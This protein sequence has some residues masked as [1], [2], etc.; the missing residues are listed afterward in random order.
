MLDR[1]GQRAANLPSNLINSIPSAA[2][3]VINSVLPKEYSEAQDSLPGV[4]EVYDIPEPPGLASRQFAVD[5]PFHLAGSLPAY[6]LPYGPMANISKAGTI[7]RIATEAVSGFVGGAQ[8]GTKSAELQAILGGTFGATAKLPLKAKMLLAPFI[9]FG[10]KEIAEWQGMDEKSATLTG[11]LQGALPI[12]SHA[13]HSALQGRTPAEVA[14]P[15]VL[16][17]EDLTRIGPS[18]S[19]E[20]FAPPQTFP[21]PTPPARTPIPLPPRGSPFVERQAEPTHIGPPFKDITPPSPTNFPV[22]AVEIPLPAGTESLASDVLGT[23]RPVVISPAPK[24]KGVTIP[25]YRS[26]E[27]PAYEAPVV[28][29]RGGMG[30]TPPAPTPESEIATLQSHE[31]VDK[32]PEIFDSETQ[33]TVLGELGQHPI[34]IKGVDG[35]VYPAVMN[36]W[37]S[38]GIPS[39][40]R[41]IPNGDWSHGILAKGEK[42][43]T[44]VPQYGSYVEYQPPV[45]PQ[46]VPESVEE[47]AQVQPEP[48][49]Q[50]PKVSR[51]K[52]IS[53]EDYDTL[54]KFTTAN[55]LRVVPGEA[56]AGS[57]MFESMSDTVVGKPSKVRFAVPEGTSYAQANKLFKSARRDRIATLQSQKPTKIIDPSLPFQN[58][59]SAKLTPAEVEKMGVKTSDI[60]PVNAPETP[61]GKG[62][63]R[64]TGGQAGASN[65]DTLVKM[66]A[67]G[68]GGAIGY[69][70][71]DEYRARGLVLGLMA[72][73]FAGHFGPKIFAAVAGMNPRSAL[74]KSFSEVAQ[75]ASRGGGDGIAKFARFF[76]KNFG[77]N[78]VIQ[79]GLSKA[80]GEAHLA[81][82]LWDRS[83]KELSARLP[84]L[85]ATER[86][87]IQQFGLSNDPAAHTAM[88]HGVSD[89]DAIA[90]AILEKDTRINAQEMVSL[91]FEP[92]SP[93]FNK[94]QDTFGEYGKTAY[95]IHFDPEFVPSAADIDATVSEL[96]AEIPSMGPDVA[97]STVEQYVHQTL[98]DRGSKGVAM[99]FANSGRGENLG[100]ILRQKKDLAARPAFRKLMGEV[101]DHV[102]VLAGTAL[103]LIPAIRSSVFFSNVADS[104]TELG[105]K[106]ALSVD[107]WQSQLNTL[108]AR[109]ATSPSD[110]AT[111]QKQYDELYHYEPTA[112]SPALGSMASKYVHRQVADKLPGMNGI[113]EGGGGVAVDMMM[114]LNNHVKAANV[115]AN[116]ISWTRAIVSMPF[117]MGVAKAGTP[118]DWVQAVRTVAARGPEFIEMMKQGILSGGYGTGEARRDLNMVLNPKLTEDGIVSLWK[119]WVT[120][121][122][123]VMDW[124]DNTVRAS[125]YLKAKARYLGQGMPPEEAITAATDWTNRYTMNYSTVS[126]GVRFAR[127]MPFINQ[128]LTYSSEI[129]RITKNLVQDVVTNHNGNRMWAAGTLFTIPALFETAQYVFENNLD[130]QTKKEWEQTKQLMPEWKR[131][132]YMLPT[133]RD[134]KT[135]AI[136]YFDIAPLMI[137]DDLTKMARAAANGDWA[138]V[139]AVN[140]VIG[141]ENTP[142]MNIITEQISGRDLRTDREFTGLMDRVDSIRTK[143]LP[144][145]F[146]GYEYD[147]LVRSLTPNNQGELGIMDQRSGK[148]YSLEDLILAYG[149]GARPSSVSLQNLQLQA[150]AQVTAKVRAIQSELRKTHL[151]NRTDAAKQQATE[152]AKRR[153]QS[154]VDEFRRKVVS[155]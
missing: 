51:G 7:G 44:P 155:I 142:A 2:Q 57:V 37:Y 52:K 75:S 107:E 77:S 112:D 129:A 5:A 64:R 6:L 141:W 39:I 93:M 9:G 60:D 28:P 18:T 105:N 146:G 89:A 108:R 68:I 87:L 24:P 125:A 26:P 53:A 8:D 69:T 81:A 34:E 67:T 56:P 48:T 95:K 110:V 50:A 148:Q 82:Q 10:A 55:D 29:E 62:L 54:D 102:E 85:P 27:P 16:T 128:Y 92:G 11:V 80:S 73:G 120:T 71:D 135:G 124:A 130:D 32:Y 94:I 65:I 4:P 136:R 103:K 12:I 117:F 22:P 76:E 49:A 106:F 72:G 154:V 147:N 79:R 97:R 133:G 145:L 150:K 40:A 83:L 111:L 36:G 35:V 123:K 91:G 21:S 88:L 113:L 86:D 46:I 140:P 101:T 14:D 126:R 1:I 19:D 153:I 20:R 45:K 59:E 115:S 127:Q 13:V 84:K 138:A 33:K 66:T 139:A 134:P 42:I 143:V 70:S 151:S 132:R 41:K 118:A 23:K 96:R 15:N 109:I 131:H 25:G 99:R 47:K 78:P 30:S 100:D 152:L 114:A 90:G 61:G 144:P 104:M 43:L 122:S 38:L 119:R 98:V 17:S 149:T 63:R 31:V 137:A 116:P 3:G 58:V 121:G 74:N